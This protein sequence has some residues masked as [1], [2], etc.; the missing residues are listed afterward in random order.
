[1]KRYTEMSDKELVSLSDE[2]IRK[3]VD[4]ELMHDGAQL[5]PDPGERPEFRLEKR[6]K[7]FETCGIIFTTREQAEAFLRLEPMTSDYDYKTG[8]DYR[9][10]IPH[11]GAEIRPVEY[12]LRDDIAAHVRDLVA[13]KEAQTLYDNAK[14]AWDKY[15]ELVTCHEKEVRSKVYAAREK[16]RQLKAHI[17]V[18]KKYLELADND[19]VTAERFF[20]QNYNRAT[21]QEVQ[22]ALSTE[23]E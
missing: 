1:M 10:V 8:Y 17:E 7:G 18:W 2:Q 21:F 15:Y 23:Q 20:L 3:L 13:L 22:D 11:R 14:K 4:I 19:A 5:A 12:H 6:W 9:F 16:A